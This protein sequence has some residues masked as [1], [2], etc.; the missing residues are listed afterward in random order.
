MLDLKK[1]V[2]LG[3]VL[4]NRILRKGRETPVC[5]A[6]V[7][8]VLVSDVEISFLVRFSRGFLESSSRSSIHDVK[9]GG[10][11]KFPFG[12]K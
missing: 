12:G 8:L 6:C 9:E 7:C 4:F 1:H 5:S 11:L 10:S 3:H 2:L